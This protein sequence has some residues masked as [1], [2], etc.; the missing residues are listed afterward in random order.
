MVDQGILIICSKCAL[1][2]EMLIIG[3]AMCLWGQKYVAISVS[4]PQGEPKT[5]LVV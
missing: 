4:S 1:W 3:K 5:A 2:W